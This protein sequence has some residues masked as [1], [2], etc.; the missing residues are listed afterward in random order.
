MDL[1][2]EKFKKKI[3]NREPF[4]VVRPADGEYLVCTNQNITNIDNWIFYANSCL[5]DDLLRS[6][7]ECEHL[8]NM[9]V[10]IPCKDCNSHI[11]NWY[12]DTLSIPSERLTYANIFCNKNWK[13]FTSLFVG[14]GVPFYYIG[15]YVSNKYNL[16]V[17]DVFKTD[18]Y[19]VNSWDSQKEYFIESFLKWMKGKNGIFVFSVGPISKILIPMMWKQNP[20][21]I[22]LDVG[23]SF[24]LFMKESSNREYTNPNSHYATTI[25][26]FKSGHKE[27]VDI[28]AILT[29]YKRPYR[30]LEQIQSIQSQTRVPRSIIVV[31][32]YVDGVQ[33]PEL[34]KDITLI[35]CSKNF[36]V[37]TRFAVGLL[38][39]TEY[40]C[41]FDD[42]TIP[43]VKWFENCL[44]SMNI[45]EG[46]YGTIGIKFPEQ[47]YRFSLDDRVGW[48]RPNTEI[49][50]VDIVGHA[51]FF[52]RAWLRYLWNYTPNYDSDLK[53]AE[54]INFSFEL[55]KAGIPTLV[56]PHPPRDYDLYGSNPV[57]AW[58][59]GC[60]KNAISGE[61]A[62]PLRFENAL[63]SAIQRGFKL[64]CMIKQV[65]PQ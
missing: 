44:H 17:T 62:A 65:D 63:N 52:K 19:L 51:W 60:D 29:L 64:L 41:V 6:L 36:G 15:P 22:Y 24:D 14:E 26:N 27:T 45:R 16:S 57:K 33:T 32:N 55:Q 5:K 47:H 34:P 35:D 9:Y 56:P 28:T 61:S 53:C 23:S 30:L 48:D 42:D 40:I 39:D 3:R 20:T 11:Y 1:D 13:S 59:Y 38:A 25:C 58:N 10:G 43:G 4:S 50:Q 18:K 37:W 12:K 31:K 46:L 49:T 8:E 21:N 7:K 54:D 2:L